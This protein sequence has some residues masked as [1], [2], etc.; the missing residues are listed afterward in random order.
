MV[1]PILYKG[2]EGQILCPR[3]W[4]SRQLCCKACQWLGTMYS[5]ALLD[6][7][8]LK[9]HPEPVGMPSPLLSILGGQVGSLD[10][11]PHNALL[12]KLAYQCQL[13][14]QAN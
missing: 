4:Q 6:Q 11:N 1:P 9:D 8:D 13:Y 14:R 10:L 5:P 2:V 3:V 7:Q 12:R